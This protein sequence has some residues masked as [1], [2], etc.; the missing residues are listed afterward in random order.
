VCGGLV[1]A[2][3][4]LQPRI[5]KSS[6]IWYDVRNRWCIRHMGA[7]FYDRFKNKDLINLLK[8]LC[9]DNQQRKFNSIWK[10][11]D[12]MTTKNERAT[13][14]TSNNGHTKGVSSRKPFFD[15]IQDVLKIP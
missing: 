3:Q 2:I 7:N 6:P 4:E 11:L 10:T 12:E 9:M 8:S 5:F 14:S 13:I 1:V 15:W